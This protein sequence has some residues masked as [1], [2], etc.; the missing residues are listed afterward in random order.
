LS[1]HQ[2]AHLVTQT[3]TLL[4]QA[5]LTETLDR[6]FPALDTT[7]DEWGAA[8]G[9]LGWTNVTTP[10]FWILDWEDWGSGPRGLDAASLWR[11]SLAVPSLADRVWRERRADLECRSGKLAVL[12]LCAHLIEAGPERAGP[13]FEPASAM[14]EEL[15]TD[16]RS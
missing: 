6:V 3:T 1:K 14:A 12:F 15:H 16:L 4:T 10:E 2:P 7:V 13:L 5:R 11:A 9:D 8:H